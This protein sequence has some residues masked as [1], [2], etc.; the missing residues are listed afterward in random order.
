MRSWYDNLPESLQS[1]ERGERVGEAADALEDCDADSKWSD[2][3]QA[4]DACEGSAERP[5][6]PEHAVGTP[7]PVCRWDGGPK[8]GR[9][10]PKLTEYYPDGQSCGF[11]NGYVG[12]I[13]YNKTRIAIE[14]AGDW[15]WNALSHN[16]KLAKRR[17]TPPEQIEAK[18]V[19][20]RKRFWACLED[21]ARY[22]EAF[23]KAHPNAVPKR[24][25]HV[26][27]VPGVE[28]FA[29]AVAALKVTLSVGK[30]RPSRADRLD[31]ALSGIQAGCEAIRI[32][33]AGRPDWAADERIDTVL[34]ACDEAGSVCDEVEAVEFPGMYG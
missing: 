6:C 21:C 31:A 32:L 20:L 17:A 33:V 7:C 18:R 2:L 26:P 5:G 30:K 13:D 16:E 23:A 3:Q 11:D 29:D 34:E 10:W 25:E 27:E 9:A 12:A 15:R 22:R 14:Y 4:I 28:G 24:R 8:T 1:A 19:E